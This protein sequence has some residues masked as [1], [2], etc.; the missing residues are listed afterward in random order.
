MLKQNEC[1]SERIRRKKCR[2]QMPNEDAHVMQDVRNQQHSP[3]SQA[4]SD[5]QAN[6]NSNGNVYQIHPRASRQQECYAPHQHSNI[7]NLHHINSRCIIESSIISNIPTISQLMMYIQDN[8][9]HSKITSNHL[10][11]TAAYSGL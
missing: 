1:R 2:L 5:F 7:F 11:H 9:I 3:L 4:I 6:S 8:I 10:N